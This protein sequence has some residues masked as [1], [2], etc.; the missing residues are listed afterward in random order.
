MEGKCTTE[1]PHLLVDQVNGT[2]DVDVN[3]IHVNCPVQ[4]L[5]TLGH[6]VW[7]GSL[8]LPK[9]HSFPE[10]QRQLFP[11]EVSDWWVMGW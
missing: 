9:G 11:W 3:K 8:Q 6:G 7:K 4:E 2:P 5:C 1:L 10:F